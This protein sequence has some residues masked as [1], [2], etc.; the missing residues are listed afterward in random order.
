MI[1]PLIETYPKTKEEM[2]K[3]PPKYRRTLRRI[4]LAF[5]RTAGS[6]IYDGELSKLQHVQ[7]CWHLPQV[8]SRGAALNSHDTPKKKILIQ[9]LQSSISQF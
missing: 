9:L 4:R 3:K 2:T 7:R 1:T 8:V 5:R 6:G